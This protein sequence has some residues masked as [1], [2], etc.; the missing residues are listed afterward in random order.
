MATDAYLWCKWCGGKG[1]MGCKE[2]AAKA[3]KERL[4]EK[5]IQYSPAIRAMFEA[6]TGEPL[7]SADLTGEPFVPRYEPGRYRD[8][9][10]CHGAGCVDCDAEADAEYHRQFP[11]GPE[12]IFTARLDNPGDLD[13]LKKVVGADVLNA[14]FAPGGLGMTEVLERAEAARLLQQ[15]G[16]E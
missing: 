2:E 3:A 12:P 13:L 15:Q 8:C 9:P 1:C 7:P 11:N 5:P 16:G 6:I 4:D 14:A 10:K